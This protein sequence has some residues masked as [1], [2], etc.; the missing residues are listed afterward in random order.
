MGTS[1]AAAKKPRAGDWYSLQLYIIAPKDAM[2]DSD[3]G[4]HLM[5][6]VCNVLHCAGKSLT[7]I[8]PSDKNMKAARQGAVAQAKGMGQLQTGGGGLFNGVVFPQTDHSDRQTTAAATADQAVGHCMTA[9]MMVLMLDGNV[10]NRHAT[11]ILSST[12]V[13]EHMSSFHDCMQQ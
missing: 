10:T 6:P 4:M 3:N 1:K 13:S 7:D 2:H 11:G 9:L 8:L 12:A 5:S